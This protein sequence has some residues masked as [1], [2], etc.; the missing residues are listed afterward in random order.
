VLVVELD[1]GSISVEPVHVGTWE[2]VQ[3]D[4]ELYGEADLDVL[5]SFL[6]SLPNKART[7]VRLGLVGKLSLAEKTRLDTMLAH[8][9]D[10]LGS[11]EAWGRR[12][13][14]VVLPTEAD[15]GAL[16]LSGFAQAA[17]AELREKAESQ[18]EGAEVARD[19][20]ALLMRLRGAA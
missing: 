2:F 17:L 3:H 16:E 19:A 15:Y 18:E 14:L 13:D 6:D 8:H 20:L 4:A 1:H 9:A 7:I 10:L 11:L 5:D 12:I